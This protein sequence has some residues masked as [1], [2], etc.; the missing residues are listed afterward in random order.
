MKQGLTGVLLAVF[1]CWGQPAVADALMQTQLDPMSL[2]LFRQVPFVA[3]WSLIVHKQ[4]IPG[5]PQPHFSLF[6][7]V[8]AGEQIVRSMGRVMPLRK[9]FGILPLRGEQHAT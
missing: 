6:Y 4:V 1:W 9:V 7:V 2:G 8:L 3:K 5:D